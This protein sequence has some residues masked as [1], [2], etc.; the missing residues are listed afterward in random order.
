MEVGYVCKYSAK[1][2][3]SIMLDAIDQSQKIRQSDKFLRLSSAEKMGGGG[4]PSGL[5][6]NN[7]SSTLKN[8]QGHNLDSTELDQSGNDNSIV[9]GM[10]DAPYRKI[11]GLNNRNIEDRMSSI[12]INIAEI[13]YQ[14][15]SSLFKKFTTLVFP[16][17]SS[18]TALS[19]IDAH[20][21]FNV[22]KFF[23]RKVTTVIKKN[24]SPQFDLQSGVSKTLIKFVTKRLTKILAPTD[25]LASTCF[26]EIFAYQN[27]LLKESK[28]KSCQAKLQQLLEN[29]QKNKL[30]PREDVG[31]QF[32]FDIFADLQKLQ[33]SIQKKKRILDDKNLE[34]EK[35][36]NIYLKQ[37]QNLNK[38]F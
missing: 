36:K 32:S 7:E 5:T 18:I 37:S 33:I 6:V 19:H 12:E 10:S 26:S 8:G 30:V 34:L 17:L 13:S 3:N 29:A 24:L 1:N 16:E 22:L 35:E 11:Y 4:L 20:Q 31:T 23:F 38:K 27:F 9:I 2:K 21:E 25:Y 15:M 14:N 28:A